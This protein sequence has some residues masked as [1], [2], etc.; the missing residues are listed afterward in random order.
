MVCGHMEYR[1]P[2][3]EEAS[4]EERNKAL[5]QSFIEEI[6][7]KHNLSAVEKIFWQGFD[8]GQSSDRDGR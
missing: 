5:M 4:R 7:N 2:S 3:T 6:F 1:V 8:G